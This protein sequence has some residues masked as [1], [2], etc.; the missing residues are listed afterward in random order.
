MEYLQKQQYKPQKQQQQ[1]QQQLQQQPQRQSRPAYK[2]DYSQHHGPTEVSRHRRGANHNHN[3]NNNSTRRKFFCR[4]CRGLECS[5]LDKTMISERT[6]N[7]EVFESCAGSNVDQQTNSFVEN[8]QSKSEYF[9][10][11]LEYQDFPLVGVLTSESMYDQQR[12][13]QFCMDF[14]NALENDIFPEDETRRKSVVA[15]IENMFFMRDGLLYHLY[16]P[17]TKFPKGTVDPD[18]VYSEIA[19]QNLQKQADKAKTRHDKNAKEP[20]F[21]VG[22]KILLKQDMIP[23]GQC[24]KLTYKRDGPY[25]IIELGPHFTYKLKHIETNKVLK[26]FMNAIRLTPYI[27]R[28]TIADQN[29]NRDAPADRPNIIDGPDHGDN[30]DPVVPMQEPP[31]QVLPNNPQTDKTTQKTDTAVQNSSQIGIPGVEWILAVLMLMF[32]LVTSS[33]TVQRLN[34]GTVFTQV[35]DLVLAKD[36]WLHTFELVFPDTFD[37][38]ML[39]MCDERKHS[40]LKISD[41]VSQLNSV[42]TNLASQMNATMNTIFELVPEAAIHKSRSKRA[43]F[44]FIGKLSKGLFG[45]ATMADVDMLAHHMNKLY[46]M[47]IGLSK[48]LSQH[49]DHLSSFISQSNERMDNLMAAI[50]DNMMEIE[51]VHS[52]LLANEANLEKALNMVMSMLIDQIQTMNAVSHQVEELKLGVV[53]LVNGHLTPLLISEDVLG[54][55]ISDI[56]EIIHHKYNGFHLS[57]SEIAQVYSDCKFIY[58]R[59]GSKL[60]I[61][62]KFPVSHFQKPLNAYKVLSLPVPINASSPHAT[63][64]MDLPDYFIMSDDRQYYT[65]LSAAEFAE[66]HGKGVKYCAHNFALK[67][68]TT[69]SCILSLFGNDKDNVKSNCDFRFIQNVIKPEIIEIASNLLLLYRTPL[70]SMECD[71]THKMVQVATIIKLRKLYVVVGVLLQSKGSMAFTT[72]LPSFIYTP[73]PT[74]SQSSGLNLQIDLSLDQ[75]N[76]ILLCA[77]LFFISVVIYRYFRFQ[78]ISKLCLE[79]TCGRQCVL[80]DVVTLPMCPA[81]FNIHVPSDIN[82]L[83]VEGCFSPKLNVFWPDFEISDNLSKKSV[84]IP[85]KLKLNIFESFKIKQILKRPYHVYLYKVHHGFMMPITNE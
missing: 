70:L 46:K 54:S 82:S 80:I 10:T 20:M 31:Q 27:E 69:S 7:N 11:T 52:H 39:P 14:I 58:A 3:R 32:G 33:P 76:F 6:S 55:T 75:A 18:K 61:S 64:L 68:V 12:K 23:T 48:A 21:Q 1:Q 59:N 74:E 44:S 40:C 56:Q 42:R 26:S 4:R 2:S 65:T 73:K 41:V 38:P 83:H 51:V 50:K 25:Q 71:L 81:H 60:Y 84:V 9:E 22:D 37:L 78:H 28:Q 63:Q 24:P 47:N 19:T 29:P 77:I 5:L 34:Y 16:T 49:E 45:T 79:I 30:P 85:S 36:S 57:I 67:P 66:C 72:N 43:L 53:N 8:C 62:I 15:Q 17:R 13:C 35:S